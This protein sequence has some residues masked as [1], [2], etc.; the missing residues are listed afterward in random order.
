[1]GADIL[2]PHNCMIHTLWFLC[3]CTDRVAWFWDHHAEIFATIHDNP[4]WYMGV[5]MFGTWGWSGNVAVTPLI[6]T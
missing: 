6:F 2:D 5:I 3:N 4:H 1:M